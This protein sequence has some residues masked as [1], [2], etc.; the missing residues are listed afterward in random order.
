MNDVR[1]KELIGMCDNDYNLKNSHNTF[2]GRIAAWG[3]PYRIRW[4]ATLMKPG[5]TVLNVGG[6]DGYTTHWF[7]ERGFKVTTV[8][9]SPTVQ[10]M[11]K[12]NLPDDKFILAFA[13][14]LDKHVT[15]QYDAVVCN[16]VIEHVDD[17]DLVL[18]QMMARVKPGGLML[19]TMPRGK[20][21]LDPLHQHF[22]YVYNDVVSQF[23]KIVDY[24]KI[25]SIAK[26]MIGDRKLVWGVVCAKED[27]KND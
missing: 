1:K 21:F 2:Q 17:V 18:K 19:V 7:K 10:E 13:E 3:E 5:G 25:F 24:F 16:Q 4:C 27:E 14:E 15:E 6:G 8:D 26:H 11:F 22:W 12:V 20:E 9:C 23:E